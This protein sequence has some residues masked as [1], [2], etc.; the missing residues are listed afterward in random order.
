MTARGVGERIV[1]VFRL[2]EFHPVF[3]NDH[4]KDCLKLTKAIQK[5]S[6]TLQNIADLYDDNVGWLPHIALFPLF[7][8]YSNVGPKNT[9]FNSRIVEGYGPSFF[10]IRG[11]P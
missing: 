4:S 11:G 5:T 7:T 2:V 6:E 10:L 9:A 1:K 8:R 3:P